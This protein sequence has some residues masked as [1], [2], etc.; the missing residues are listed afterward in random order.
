M[1]EDD[2]I[3][4]PAPRAVPEKKGPGIMG[5][6]LALLVSTVLG[7]G[8][9]AMLALNQVE[10]IAAAEKKK[11]TEV[12]QKV[13]DALAWDAQSTVVDL[14]PVIT[15][16]ASP[17]ETWLRLET[18]I[19]IQK[20]KVDDVDR[21]KAEAAASILAFA[22]TLTVNEVQG[23]SALNHLRDDL[24]DHVRFQS[25]EAVEELIIK[26]MILQ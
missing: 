25:Q 18:A 12:P 22:R 15:N 17:A 11:A 14:D 13:D 4:N 10:T 2:N 9:G 26:A 16:L 5:L 20:E 19:V 21:L 23:A 7:V 24:N 6:V 3:E 1:D 8:G